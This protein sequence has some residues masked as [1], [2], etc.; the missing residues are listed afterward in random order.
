MEHIA[1]NVDVR[2]E[3]GARG[4]AWIPRAA[5]MISPS[6]QAHWQRMLPDW[7]ALEL[8]RYLKNGATFRRRRYGRFSWSPTDS[9]LA[10]LP[11]ESYFQPEDEN[12]YAGGIVR[13]FAPLL[14]A[15]VD[16]PWL[17]ALVRTTFACLPVPDAR[18]G[19]NWEVRVHQIRIVATSDQPGLPA[20]EGTH[21]DGTDFL[22]LHLVRRH[23]I[24]GGVSTIYDLDRNP[25][26]SFTLMEPLDSLILEDPRVMHGVT[27][28]FAADGQSVGTRDLIGLD[29]IHSPR[30]QRP[31]CPL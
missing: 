4:F 17:R 30:L 9:E 5:W 29:F 2:H 19:S 6:L 22:T 28:V 1:F 12:S 20:P 11:R 13:E 26:R 10:V 8:D 7:D 27:P 24:T 21:Q 16:N 15:T 31:G 23:N 14:P 18:Q 25:I 3:L